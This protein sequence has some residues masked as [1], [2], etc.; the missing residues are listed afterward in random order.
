MTFFYLSITAAK[1]GNSFIF[2]NSCYFHF[3]GCRKMNLGKF[4]ETYVGFLKNVV[5][6]LFSK[7]YQSYINLKVKSS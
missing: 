2:L 1:N 3:G 4:L 6:Q 5:L 7:Y